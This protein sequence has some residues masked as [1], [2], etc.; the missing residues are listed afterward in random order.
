MISKRQR[1]L[2]M[3]LFENFDRVGIKKIFKNGHIW[4]YETLKSGSP[5]IRIYYELILACSVLSAIC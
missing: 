4:L 5:K 3:T 2:K 1:S